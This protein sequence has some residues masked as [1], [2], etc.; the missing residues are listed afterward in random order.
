LTSAE[1][2]LHLFNTNLQKKVMCQ[3][4]NALKESHKTYSFPSYTSPYKILKMAERLSM[5]V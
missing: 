5:Y 1:I 2:G 4:Q 3:V